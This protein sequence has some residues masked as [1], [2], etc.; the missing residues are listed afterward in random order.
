MSC[1]CCV[2]RCGD[3]MAWFAQAIVFSV[4]FWGIRFPIGFLVSIGFAEQLVFLFPKVWGFGDISL[5]CPRSALDR[6]V[7][8][9]RIDVWW[10]EFAGLVQ[11]AS[12][13][14]TLV[15]SLSGYSH[16]WSDLPVDTP[17]FLRLFKSWN[18]ALP[19]SWFRWGIIYFNFL[20]SLFPCHR[21]WV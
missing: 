13:Y 15:V 12:W 3:D 8:F 7:L 14:F 6:V 18:S 20:L 11:L 9:S 5:A 2:S 19:K 1:A 16:G 21:D 17:G 10:C 4:T